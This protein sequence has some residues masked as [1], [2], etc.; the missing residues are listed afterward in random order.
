MLRSDEEQQARDGLARAAKSAPHHPQG[1]KISALRKIVHEKQAAR[2]G[3]AFVDMAT[4]SV[5]LKVYD[6][7][8]EKNQANFASRPIK[9]MAVIAWKLIS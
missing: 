1:D 4:A 9:Q 8:N 7:L 5:I 6:A 3:G 2:V